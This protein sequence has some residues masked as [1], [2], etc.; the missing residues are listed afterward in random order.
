MPGRILGHLLFAAL[1]YSL[2]VVVQYRSNNGYHVCF[3]N[4]CPYSLGAPHANVYNTLKRKVPLPH[5]HRIFTP[6]LLEYA[7][8]SLDT[9]IDGQDISY[10]CTGGCEVG[11]VVQG[12]DERQSRCAVQRPAVIK[13]RSNS[14][15]S[16]VG[17][18]DAKVVL[19][20]DRGVVACVEEERLEAVSPGRLC[21]A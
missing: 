9:A 15:A 1:F 2:D 5:F 19:P 18:W 16:F 8:Q 11:E 10:S 13:G 3:H 20:H 12:V 17:I 4:S 14:N 21:D 6:S 7:Y